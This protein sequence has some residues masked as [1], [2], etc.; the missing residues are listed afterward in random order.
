MRII[1]RMATSLVLHVRPRVA[2]A[3]AR[4]ERIKVPSE[5]AETQQSVHI[6]PIVAR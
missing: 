5:E 1:G 2:D 6:P 3:K 4:S